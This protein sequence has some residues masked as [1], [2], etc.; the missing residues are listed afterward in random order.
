MSV[1]KT[2]PTCGAKA[3]YSELKGVNAYKAVQNDELYIKIEQLNKAAQRFKDK[4]ELLEK[5][6]QILKKEKT[7]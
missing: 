3:K 4:A 2:C 6:I 1:L 7:N 5:E